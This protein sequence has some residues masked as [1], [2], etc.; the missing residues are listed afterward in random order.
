MRDFRDHPLSTARA[1][2]SAFPHTDL[3]GYDLFI[4]FLCE[5]HIG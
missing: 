5:Y 2:S 4:D 3:V 1:G